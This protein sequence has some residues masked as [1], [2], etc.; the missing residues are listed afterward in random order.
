MAPKRR[1]SAN[2]EDSEAT[3]SGPLSVK[4]FGLRAA[5][6][7]QSLNYDSKYHPMDNI[8]RPGYAK[9]R[10]MLKLNEKSENLDECSSDE[11]SDKENLVSG[12]A[13]LE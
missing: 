8:T 4:D 9:K 5:H 6:T 12:R 7:N 1:S 2:T 11:D 10:R 3:I 13:L